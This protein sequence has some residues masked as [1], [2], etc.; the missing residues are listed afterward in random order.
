MEENGG[1][2]DDSDHDDDDSKFSLGFRL[3]TRSLSLEKFLP[4][5]LTKSTSTTQKTTF[6]RKALDLSLTE[7]Q[8]DTVTG[9]NYQSHSDSLSHSILFDTTTPFFLLILV[10]NVLLL[11]G[12]AFA[13]RRRK[14]N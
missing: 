14:R 9:T 6:E 12:T 4:S 7:S 5:F 13:L 11:V 3:S 10:G 8:S 2:G 1:G